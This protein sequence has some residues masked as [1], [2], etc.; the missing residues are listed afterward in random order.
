MTTLNVF[1]QFSRLNAVESIQVKPNSYGNFKA[2]QLNE[3]FRSQFDSIL[4]QITGK[5]LEDNH[6]V[7]SFKSDIAGFAD[8]TYVSSVVRQG[9][10]LAIHLGTEILPIQTK[11]PDNISLTIEEVVYDRYRELSLTAY[12]EDADTT[13]AFPLRLSEDAFKSMLETLP[14]GKKAVNGRKL[15]TA[16]AKGKLDVVVAAL[17]EGKTGGSS[18]PLTE[19]KDLPQQTL[20]PVTNLKTVSVNYQGVPATSYIVTVNHESTEHSFWLP[21][22]LKLAAEIGTIAPNQTSIAY[23]LTEANKAGKQYVKGYTAKMVNAVTVDTVA[24]VEQTDTT[25]TTV[26]VLEPVKESN[27]LP[28]SNIQEAIDWAMSKLGDRSK[29][30]V[31][32]MLASAPKDENGSTSLGFYNMVMEMAVV[33]F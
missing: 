7:L 9:D 28:F 8:K 13:I 17:S 15:S 3:A 14:D 4:N 33:P 27:K 18:A 30:E 26:E 12:D 22:N 1:A 11:L 20:F 24:S 16:M 31:S 32:D 29:T 2:S 6:S 10:N 23:Y 25:Q 19:I 21:S 5:T